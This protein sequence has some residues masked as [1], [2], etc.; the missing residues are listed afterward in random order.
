[1]IKI[2][3]GIVVLF[4]STICGFLYAEKFQ[5]RVKELNEI[6]RCLYQ[7]RNE[8]L[9]THT[10]LTQA[11]NNVANKALEPYS[12][13]FKVIVSNLSDRNCNDVYEAF[14]LAVELY[15]DEISITKEDETILLDLSKSL[16]ETDIEGQLMVFELSIENIK[17]RIKEAE[18]I[19]KKNVKMYR[20]LG[21]CL[22]AM[23]VIMLV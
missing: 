9:Y 21:F 8:I 17:K 20:C 10:P 13:F 22:G 18:I 19:M 15:E 4:A 11:L 3:G 1:M 23:V 2:L 16:G 12:S 5:N 14:K 6:E 7:L